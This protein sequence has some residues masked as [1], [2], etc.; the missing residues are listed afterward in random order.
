MSGAF[1]REGFVRALTQTLDEA[2]F[3]FVEGVEPDGAP[4][5]GDTVVE[6]RIPFHGPAAGRI[7]LAVSLEHAVELAANLLGVDPAA[8]EAASA[9]SDALGELANILCGVLL[10]R[11]FPGDERY[12]MGTPIVRRIDVAAYAA[13]AASAALRE[14]LVTDE[15][16]RID[17]AVFPPAHGAGA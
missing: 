12:G 6:A 13:E 8:P 5:G 7:S 11:W 15:G 4:W 9:A 10:E 3:V 2:A 17:A 1:D 14:T 16:R